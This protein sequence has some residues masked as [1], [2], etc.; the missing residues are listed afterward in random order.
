M[1]SSPYRS[2]CR[3]SYIYIGNTQYVHYFV[4]GCCHHIIIILIIRAFLT[5]LSYICIE[6]VFLLFLL[7]D[8]Y[9]PW[10]FS[11]TSTFGA[12]S[13]T[14]RCQQFSCAANSKNVRRICGLT[15]P[16]Q[17]RPAEIKSHCEA[18]QQQGI[19]TSRSN[20]TSSKLTDR[21]FSCWFH[22][23]PFEAHG[24]ESVHLEEL[25]KRI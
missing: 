24:Y 5:A 3:R 1:Y 21:P 22:M 14:W 7:L 18:K 6:C 10:Q 11:A 17:S 12:R 4:D 23:F 16:R 20:R 25:Q 2:I 15:S 9:K 8:L 13:C 19:S